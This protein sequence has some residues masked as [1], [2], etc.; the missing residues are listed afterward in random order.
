MLRNDTRT[1]A[2]WREPPVPIYMDF[3]LFHWANPERTLDGTEK[4]KFV[5]KGPYVFREYHKKENITWNENSTVTFMQVRKWIFMKNLTKTNLSLDDT[6]TS[7]NP[8]FFTVASLLKSKDLSLIKRLAIE[9]ALR[10]IQTKPYVS[11]SVRQLL[12]E[13][14]DDPLL[15]ALDKLPQKIFPHPAMAKRFGWFYPHNMSSE[16]DGICNVGTGVDSLKNLGVLNS[17]NYNSRTEFFEGKCG[18]VKGTTGDIWPP[19]SAK[20]NN[21]TLYASDLCSSLVLQKN[22]RMSMDGLD[23]TTFVGAENVFDNGTLFPENKCYLANGTQLR[24]GVRSLSSCRF[25]APILI[26]FPHFY[27]ADEFYAKAIDGVSPSVENHQF[28]ISLEKNTGIPLIVNARLQINVQS[29]PTPGYGIFDKLPEITLPAL[30]FDQH[31]LVTRELADGIWIVSV[32]PAYIVYG[33]I[34]VSM[35]GAVL[36]IYGILLVRR[37]CKSSPD[38]AEL[39]KD[40]DEPAI[41][42]APT[43]SPVSN[44]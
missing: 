38:S 16:F 36:I 18:E 31:M 8:I 6:I 33:L 21:V 41:T 34:A 2:M 11:K 4:P 7:V 37:D 44:Q 42:S 35:L 20:E 14:Y 32:M 43:E 12:Y 17:W 3:Y 9:A 5:E 27:L 25:G 40:T 39:L 24:K 26:S 1:F 15:A 19:S 10:A 13:G 29:S 22:G 30:W 28:K 23:G